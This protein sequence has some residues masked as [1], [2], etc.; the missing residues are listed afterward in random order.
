MIRKPSEE[1]VIV[2]YR[3][4]LPHVLNLHTLVEVA[5][6]MMALRDSGTARES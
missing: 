2:S 5:R 6:R 3:Y 4:N 1:S